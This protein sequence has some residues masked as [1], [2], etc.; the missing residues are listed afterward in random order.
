MPANKD[1]YMQEYKRIYDFTIQE[2]EK[3]PILQEL[4]KVIAN[5]ASLYI[6]LEELSALRERVAELEKEKKQ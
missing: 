2:K 5:P 3:G 4:F 6:I 1:W